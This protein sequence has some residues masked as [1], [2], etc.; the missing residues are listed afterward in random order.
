[1][2]KR[3]KKV[4]AKV[5]ATTMLATTVTA[6]MGINVSALQPRATVSSST[7]AGNNRYET[8]VKISENGWTSA[9]NAVLINGDNGLVDALTATPYANLKN[10]PI[11][12]T[13]KDSLTPVTKQ[14]LIK[15][16]VKNVDIVGGDAV[17]S[18]KVVSELK[19][20][21][22]TV[23]RIAGTNRYK[24]AVKVAEA[25]DKIYDV[26][27]IAV[28]NGL[29][30]LPDAVSVAAP[31]AENK[32]PII[33]SN[34]N[35]GI[36]DA[37]A[38]IDGEG[39]SKSYVIG[40]VGA[41][42]NTIMNSLPGTKVRLGGARRQETNAK[43]I[44]EFYPSA[45][46]SNIYV[47][48]SGQ[49]NKADEL[50]DALSVGVLAA[51]KGAPVLLVGKTL[52]ASQ[53]SLL[54]SKTF[55]QITQ[56]GGGIPSAA[57][58][59]IK[60]TQNSTK[61]VTTVAALNSA[62]STARDG[63]VI[64]F[65][66][67][68]TVSENITL[69][70]SSNVTVNLHGAHTGTVNAS[71]SNGTLNINGNISNTV[72]I[73]GAKSVNV[74]SGVTVKQ[75]DVKASAKNASV[76]NKGTITTFNVVATGVKI[77]GS[78]NITTL[79]AAG[80]TD[81]SGVTGNIGNLDKSKPVSQVVAQNA[82]EIVVRFSR[83]LDAEPTVN[84]TG[85]ANSTAVGTNITKELSE[86]RMYMTI[87]ANNTYYFDGSYGLE[88]S[89]MSSNG[90][91]LEIYRNTITADDN[92]APSVSNVVYNQSENKFE[93]NLSEPID[94][95][96]GIVLRAN[97]NP[98]T[99]DA[100]SGNSKKI[101]FTKPTSI[102]LNTN[103]SI[104]LAGLKDSVNNVMNSYTGTV[105]TSSN[106]LDISSFTQISNTEMKLVFN[107]KLT[108]ASNNDL[109]VPKGISLHK[110][111]GNA[112]STNP[113]TI[114]IAKDTTD[115][116]GRTYII[117][118]TG[119]IP[120]D[121][122]SQVVALKI[123]K[124]DGNNTYQDE[125][126]TNI[127]E[128]TRELTLNK[129]KVA[130]TVASAVISSNKEAIELTMS[131]AVNILSNTNVKLRK[132][133]VDLN[134]ATI[135]YKLDAYGNQI[136]NKLLVKTTTASAL[137]G[138]KLAAGNYQVFLS[139]GAVTDL[140]GIENVSATFKNLVVTADAAQTLNLGDITTVSGVEN[141]FHINAPSG[142]K[143]AASTIDDVVIKIDGKVIPT[144]SDISFTNIDSNVL[145]VV[146]PD[147]DSVN[148]SGAAE[149]EVS[150]VKLT[151]G[152]SVNSKKAT[153]ILT[154][155]TDPTLTSAVV[156]ISNNTSVQ[157]A[158]IK[159]T[160]D[161]NMTSITGSDVSALEDEL[162]IKRVTGTTEEL[163]NWGKEDLYTTADEAEYYVNGK[164]ITITITAGL[165]SNLLD[166]LAKTSNNTSISI[167]T[168]TPT[169]EATIKDANGRNARVDKK[170]TTKSTSVNI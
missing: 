138:N 23:S 163:Y 143:F 7:I 56:V 26:S 92:T 39:I 5:M 105:K 127:A 123:A 149:I 58:E 140:N 99:P 47:A 81:F 145:K 168:K 125:T 70:T 53:D 72:S 49:V 157:K 42:S 91:P 33:L 135:E 59:S 94:S 69:S 93:I 126:G 118:S 131:E 10:A 66:P 22:I 85:G 108:T 98:V 73:N 114:T 160:F 120:T 37:K 14:R 15:M 76:S 20:M 122:D 34:P 102:A 162:I 134:N 40:E 24:T 132:D 154:D 139:G 54:R 35:T 75:L 82:K 88:L 89:G 130:P 156:Q 1:M 117:T 144:T 2:L 141:T 84:I 74:N 8:A 165:N 12:V 170:V 38:F 110:K 136:K 104:Y 78:G 21:N 28:V 64:N 50:V 106:K 36:S 32:M 129:D 90:N 44:S 61:D 57:I 109:I 151:S 13:H 153:I 119:I 71:L 55:T 41:V 146:L 30:G 51:K 167:S 161:E 63:D 9:T 6:S 52:D 169:T 86:N 80:D 62:L 46:L 148:L 115:T 112:I 101:T 60:N 79:N 17:V 67:T 11:L 158:I 19:S 152:E 77:S 96:S 87:T 133:G 29:T 128:V 142:K 111:N 147:K 159:L 97:G 124:Y 4:I 83:P 164:V 48:K 16:G 113:E 95:L 65:R 27:K 100:I 150:N 18:E 107:K 121:K 116:T 137:N 45:S 25:M 43:V 103:V 155:N 31:A 3:K 68:A 166:V